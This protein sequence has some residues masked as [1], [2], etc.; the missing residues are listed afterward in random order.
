MAGAGIYKTTDGGKTWTL[1]GLPGTNTIARIV[2]HPEN[3]NIVYVAASGHEWTPNPDRGVFRTTDGGQTWQKV[4]FVD[5]E[6]GAID[7]VM[8]PSDPN[9]LYAATWQRTRRKWHTPATF[10]HYSGSGIWK[11]T[12]A[13]NTW[14]PINNGLVEA[15]YRG[16][17]GIDIARSRPN[18]LYAVID[19]HEI[20]RAAE[21]GR[22]HPYSGLPAEPLIRGAT[23]Y[24]S[25]D[26]GDSWRRVSEFE[27]YWA[28]FGYAFS[29]IRVDPKNENKIY[30]LSLI[31][32]L[33][34]DGGK[35]FRGIDTCG[36][37]PDPRGLW[38][39]PVNSDYLVQAHDA[40]VHG[41]YDGGKNWR[42]FSGGLPIAQFY[43]AAYDMDTPFRVYGSVQDNYSWRSIVDLSRG[44]NNIPARAW[45]QAPGGEATRHAIDPRTPATVYASNFYGRLLRYDFPTNQQMKDISLNQFKHIAPKADKGEP[46]LRGQWLAPTILSPH[47]PDVVYHGFQYVFRSTDRGESW[48]RISPDL[49]SNDTTKVGNIPYQTIY[50]IAESPLRFGLI[51]AGTDDG[52]LHVTRDGGE[53]WTEIGQALRREKF[54][55]G[56]VA[57]KYD[58]GTVYV[59]Q[60]G[61]REDDFAPYLWKSTDY[62]KTW[63]SIVGNLTS[64][65]VNVIKEDPK[66]A[67]LLYLGTD[68]GVYVSVD[69]GK[70]WQA[71]PT[72]MP[73][74]YVHDLAIHPREDIMVAATHGRGMFALD[75]RPIQQLTP[76]MLA[77]AVH[78]L[79]PE[80]A[81]LKGIPPPAY[82][83]LK[84]AG[85]VLVTI[86]DHTG[87][88]VRELETSGN[89]GLNLITWDLRGLPPAGATTEEGRLQ[90]VGPGVYMVKV[91]QGVNAASA[92]VQVSW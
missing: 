57:S 90:D 37:C 24:R 88:T 13:G 42:S 78:V 12:D 56:I 62:G 84:R 50:S 74:A 33:S 39:D 15:R 69:G 53:G 19:N 4:L 71:L 43:N 40:G 21:P 61:R 48:Q 67:N 65:P 30:W 26:R 59:A 18:V 10:P 63:K 54:I 9:T 68:H 80:P 16:R 32:R 60:N 49:T 34:Q 11:S 72:G 79:P 28:G 31:L 5:Q 91:R 81:V 86:S 82:Y 52:H 44:R 75:V 14:K 3:T 38:I 73:T 70:Q 47:N 20:A 2:I 77:S 66:H 41:S 58:E 27:D 64:G 51:Y 6:T 8:D 85:P 1:M 7:L 89:A 22:H 36:N 87:R 83:W 29:Q 92:F 25:D 76:A 46:V 35:T 17:I 45:E 55:V 23:V